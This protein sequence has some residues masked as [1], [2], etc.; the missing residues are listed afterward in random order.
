[1]WPGRTFSL[2]MKV[3]TQTYKQTNK[4]TNKIKTQKPGSAVSSGGDTSRAEPPGEFEIT[5]AVC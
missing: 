2:H 3:S 5:T 4:Q 1:M